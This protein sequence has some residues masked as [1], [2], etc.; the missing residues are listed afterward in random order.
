VDP[1]RIGNGLVPGLVR[2]YGKT[3]R[4]EIVEIE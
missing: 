2:S 3:V 4:R 1:S